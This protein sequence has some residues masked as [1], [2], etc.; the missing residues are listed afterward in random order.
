MI[1][2]DLKIIYDQERK[3]RVVFFQRQNGTLGFRAEYFSE[4]PYE[5][6][7]MPKGPDDD[8]ICDNWDILMREAEGRIL[9]LCDKKPQD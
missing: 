9:W 5:Q 1:E 3:R 6:C 8:S 4:D 2:K 7:W